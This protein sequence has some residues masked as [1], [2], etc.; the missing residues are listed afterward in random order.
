MI[1]RQSARQ[2]NQLL[3]F[4]I[5]L[6]IYLSINKNCCSLIVHIFFLLFFSFSLDMFNISHLVLY[7]HSTL[8]HSYDNIVIFS[9]Q[10]FFFLEMFFFQMY[11]CSLATFPIRCRWPTG[12]PSFPPQEK[13]FVS[14]KHYDCNIISSNQPSNKLTRSWISSNK[15]LY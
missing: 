14:I 3:I 5:L 15:F 7:S 1:S 8:I 11:S 12:I 2:R 13:R 6:L 9:L 4:L 10:S